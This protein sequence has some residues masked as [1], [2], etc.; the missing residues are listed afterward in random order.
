MSFIE[1]II[2]D[3]FIYKEEY[4]YY[5]VKRGFITIELPIEILS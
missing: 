4:Q 5:Y 1:K 3:N 2:E